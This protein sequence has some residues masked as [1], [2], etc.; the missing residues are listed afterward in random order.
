MTTE[1]PETVFVVTHSYFF[2]EQDVDLDE[3]EGKFIGVF[4]SHERA[5]GAI[6]FLI[7]QPGFI[8]RPDDFVITPFPV[9]TRISIAE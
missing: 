7:T 4:S 3:A 8:D 2:E 1:L 6:T 9:Q 5:S